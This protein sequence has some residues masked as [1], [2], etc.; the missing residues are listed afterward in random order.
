MTGNLQAG[1]VQSRQT[2]FVRSCLTLRPVSGKPIP[3]SESY[4]KSA[5]HTFFRTWSR[6]DDPAA[7]G[8]RNNPEPFRDRLPEQTCPP[9]RSHSEP[10]SWRCPNLVPPECPVPDRQHVRQ[11]SKPRYRPARPV[12]PADG[13][14]QGAD[15][16]GQS[17]LEIDLDAAKQQLQST[18]FAEK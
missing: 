6:C 12:N 3:R 10:C 7:D 8:S 14:F 15:V 2:L 13:T 17:V 18:V 5:L 16:G 4:W 1:G 9:S 11:F